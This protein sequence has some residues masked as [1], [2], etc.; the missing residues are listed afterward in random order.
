MGSNLY[1][2]LPKPIIR[3]ETLLLPAP[4]RFLTHASNAGY[5]A[6][7]A[8]SQRFHSIW[9]LATGEASWKGMERYYYCLPVKLDLVFEHGKVSLRME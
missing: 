3:R 5:P 1:G 4:L 7:T 6:S 9:K 2:L 8:G